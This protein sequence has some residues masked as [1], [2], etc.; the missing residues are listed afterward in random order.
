MG[1][2]QAAKDS[3]SFFNDKELNLGRQRLFYPEF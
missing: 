1:S 2:A 3:L